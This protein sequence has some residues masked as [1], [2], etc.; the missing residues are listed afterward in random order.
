MPQPSLHPLWGA[1]SLDR[2]SGIPL[3]DQIAEFFRSAI[4]DERIVAGKRVPSSRQFAAEFGISRTTAVC[5][6]ERLVAEGYFATR[7]GSG[8]F[9]ANTRPE[10]FLLRAR[11]PVPP[12]ADHPDFTRVDMRN[13]L[14]PLAPGMP[15]IDRFPWQTWN[16]LLAQVCRERPLNAIGYGDPQGELTLRETI[17]EYLASARGI[18]CDASQIIV[19]A[20]SEQ[21]L[22]FVLAEVTEPGDAAWVEDPCGPYIR[23]LAHKAG[24][25]PIALTVD[26]EGLDVA[27]EIGRA[28]V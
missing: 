20:G 28:H 12:A 14:L 16:R 22:E 10:H 6:Y 19:M 23:N 13:Y 9:V 24:I 21:S 3:Q 17:A 8:V 1:L 7:P 26:A 18:A 4:A 27:Q 2:A 5:A 11:A 15:A 25:A